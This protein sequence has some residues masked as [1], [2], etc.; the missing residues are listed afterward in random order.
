M[1]PVRLGTAA[2][3]SR[4]KHST[5]EA[6]RYPHPHPPPPPPPPKKKKKK[7]KEKKRKSYVLPDLCDWKPSEH[8]REGHRIA[9]GPI[10]ARDSVLTRN[11]TRSGLQVCSLRFNCF[12]T[13]DKGVIFMIGNTIS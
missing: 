8:K 4:V 1:T 13:A 9:G 3:R 10:V 5:T 11:A 12:R 2:P 7:K 6:L